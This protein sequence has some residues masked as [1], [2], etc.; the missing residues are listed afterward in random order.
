MAKLIGKLSVFLPCY[1]EEG[2]IKEVVFAVKNVLEEVAG[3]WELLIIDDGSKDATQEISKSLIQK[4]RRIKIVTHK[5]NEGYGASLRSGFYS[6]KYPWIAYIDSDGQFN[7]AEI[8]SFIKKQNETNADL[9]IGYY[10]KRQVSTFKILTSKIWEF[11]VF[12]LFG[13]R[14]RDTDCAFKLV[15]K[16]VIDTITPLESRRGA[17]IS[18]E[19]LIKSV[20]AG[21]T[22]AEVP[23]THYPRTKGAGTGR[24]LNVIIKSFSDLFRLW[25]KLK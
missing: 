21:F 15:S 1:N 14:V 20:G 4:D 13:L 6:S 8:V 10:K 16:K 18:S 2:N 19:L 23:V 24:D 12:V 3:E 17:F 5:I 9:I 11:A 25:R 7:F 22:V